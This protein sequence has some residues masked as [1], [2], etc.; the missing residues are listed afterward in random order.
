MNTHKGIIKDSGLLIELSYVLDAL[1]GAKS[2]SDGR[3]SFYK[4]FRFILAFYLL[5][6]L[7]DLFIFIINAY[8]L[9]GIVLINACI[10]IDLA[11]NR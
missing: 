8:Q 6:C 2:V 10:L 9:E 3:T 4:L 1:F 11:N 7:K 5:K